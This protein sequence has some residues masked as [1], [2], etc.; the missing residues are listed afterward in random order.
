MQTREQ[1]AEAY[2]RRS[3]VT[4]EWL[5]E[6]GREPRRCDCEEEGCEGWQMAH[7]REL[8]WAVDR[9]IATPAEIALLADTEERR[10]ES[11]R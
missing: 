1:F 11:P 10:D 8:Q 4:V 7:I 6:H 3:G 2:A 9:G 5:R